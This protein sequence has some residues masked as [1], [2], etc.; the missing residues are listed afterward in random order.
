MQ[1]EESV[2]K[3]H[4]Q[5][6]LCLNLKKVICAALF[7]IPPISIKYLNIILKKLIFYL[8]SKLPR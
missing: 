6:S 7:P 1:H 3:V 2:L 4:I 5:N 8:N